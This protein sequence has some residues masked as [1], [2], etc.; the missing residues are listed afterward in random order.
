MRNRLAFKTFLALLAFLLFLSPYAFG[1]QIKLAWDPPTANVDGSPLTDL[2]GYKIHWG[3]SSGTYGD[4]VDVGEVTNYLLTDLTEGE[5][6]YIVVTAYDTFVPPEESDHSNEVTGVATN[7]VAIDCS[8]IGIQPQEASF[9]YSGGAGNISVTGTSGTCE[10]AATVPLTWVNITSGSTGQGNGMIEYRIARNNTPVARNGIIYISGNIFDIS[11]EPYPAN[12]VVEP[13]PMDFGTLESGKIAELKMKISN[14]G[15][16]PLKVDSVEIA[17]LDKSKFWVGGDCTIIPMGSPCNVVV[18]FVPTISG[19]QSGAL[20]INSDDPVWPKY[21]VALRGAAA[22][23]AAPSISVS[24]DVI[25]FP[26]VEMEFGYSQTIRLSNGGTG[27]LVINSINVEGVDGTEFSVNSNCSVVAPYGNCDFRLSGW[28]SSLKAKQISVVIA[29]NAI[30]APKLEIPVTVSSGQCIGW[31]INLSKT[32][33]TVAN[34]GANGTVDVTATGTGRCVLYA[35]SA[36]P[37]IN[38]SVNNGS[39]NYNVTANT[40]GFLRIGNI[41][42]A[43]QP[44]TIIQNSGASDAIFNDAPDNVFDDYINGLYAAGITVGCGQQGDVMFYC[45]MEHVTRGQM[46]AFITRAI[47][48]ETFYY[49]AGPYFS[50]MPN[51]HPFFKYVQ[52]MKDT[53]ITVVSGR[54]GV[55]DNVTRGQVAAFIIRAIYG[56]TFNFTQTPYFIDVPDAHIF[57]KYVQK[58]KDTGITVVN[59]IYRVDDYVTREEMAAFLA[60]AFLGM[61]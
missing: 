42:I 60:R 34:G 2:G 19:V 40:S 52:K 31:D 10:W 29:S 49:P 47:H 30:N 38:V 58:M 24:P 27:S 14:I 9:P 39:V 21:N 46:A 1:A 26:Y 15:S 57:F 32:S 54:Y 44:F 18:A 20:V 37:W 56:E 5:T 17:E 25:N 12:I 48:G 22:D 55:D 35:I 50:D 61:K 33:Q 36:R 16:T 53:G 3:S 11:Q 23:N 13:D 28:F 6:Y 4:P 41:S 59:E 43:G 8:T 7:P 51:T 45:P